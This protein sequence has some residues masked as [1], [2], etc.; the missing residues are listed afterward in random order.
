MNKKYNPPFDQLPLNGLV[1]VGKSAGNGTISHDIWRSL[2]LVFPSTNPLSRCFMGNHQIFLQNG[3][4]A[5]TS[6]F[7]SL[8][9]YRKCRIIPPSILNFKWLNKF[10]KKIEDKNLLTYPPA[11]R[12][13]SDILPS[14]LAP[15]RTWPRS[16]LPDAPS[17]PPRSPTPRSPSARAARCGPARRSAGRT[18]VPHHHLHWW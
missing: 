17:R 3:Y 8:L 16:P 2:V 18:W 5:M 9:G 1:L 10:Q 15:C 14:P 13:P 4:F 12:S 11:I 7:T 6:C